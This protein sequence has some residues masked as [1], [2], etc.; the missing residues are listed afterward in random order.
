MLLLTSVVWPLT[1]DLDRR[2]CSGKN[3][4]GA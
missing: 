2:L 1:S 4:K 3:V